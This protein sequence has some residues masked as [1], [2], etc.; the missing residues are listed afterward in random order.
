MRIGIQRRGLQR[1]RLSG[2]AE[3]DALLVGFLCTVSVF[4]G[5]VG[6]GKGDGRVLVCLT[7]PAPGL[8]T[9]V[10]SG[11]RGDGIRALEAHSGGT[12][13]LMCAYR[14]AAGARRDAGFVRAATKRGAAK[15]V[16]TMAVPA[17]V[18]SAV[19][20]HPILKN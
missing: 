20:V 13:A 10:K 18:I 8:R 19:S 17:K 6:A 1:S 9:L 16:R 3:G 7:V 4:L 11:R 2:L 5:I 15:I 12:R 14:E